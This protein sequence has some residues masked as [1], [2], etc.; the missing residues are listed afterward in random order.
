[1]IALGAAYAAGLAVGY[2]PSTDTIT[3]NWAEGKRWHPAMAADR[4]EQLVKS[5]QQ[6]LNWDTG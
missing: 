4:R 1:M 3:T 6:G 2:W 5:C